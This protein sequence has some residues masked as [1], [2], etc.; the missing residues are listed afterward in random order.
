MIL[1]NTN[2]QEQKSCLNK[3]RGLA[4][5]VC[6]IEKEKESCVWLLF[7]SLLLV[8]RFGLEPRHDVGMPHTIKQQ[9]SDYMLE[10][11]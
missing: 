10:S 3:P 11:I 7:G 6:T 1:A 9:G 8:V 5:L 4:K 2:K